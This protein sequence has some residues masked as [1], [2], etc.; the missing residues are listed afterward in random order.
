M[1]PL[2]TYLIVKLFNSYDSNDPHY[3]LNVPIVQ[4]IHI[5]WST[6]DDRSRLRGSRR[7]WPRLH[8]PRQ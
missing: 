7:P 3:T 6:S 2:S 8:L 4:S 5:Q 1:V